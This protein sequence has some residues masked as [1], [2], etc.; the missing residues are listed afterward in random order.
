[1]EILGIDVGGSGVKSALVNV[2]TGKLLDEYFRI[3][4][5]NPATPLAISLTFKEVLAHFE[6]EKSVGVGFPA[7]VKNGIVCTA[8]NIDKEWIGV[9][10]AE[11]FKNK[12]G[13]AMA[14]LNDADAAGIA[15][16]KFGAGKGKK[17]TILMLTVGTGIGTS[18]FVD[19]NLFPNIELGQIEFNG[20][21]AEKYASDA[22]RE[23]RELTWAEWAHRFNKYI[24]E[25]EKLLWPDLIILGGGVSKRYDKY[26]KQLCSK[27][28]I[29]PAQLLNNAGIIGAA[30][31]ADEVLKVNK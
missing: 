8:T 2:K 15:E 4:T 3:P 20:K 19:G 29:L 1:M 10:A 24:K 28:P 25:V 14:V 18:L 5:P 7:V 17:G 23:K 26:S 22:T 31:Y 13:S 30:L 27:V 21:N 16:I 6:W 12:T 9:N 11:L